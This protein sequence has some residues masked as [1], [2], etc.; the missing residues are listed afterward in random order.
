MVSP[1]R[2][3]CLAALW[4]VPLTSGQAAAQVDAQDPPPPP[5]LLVA[6]AGDSVRLL[7]TVAPPQSGGFHV[8]RTGPDGAVERLTT[9][10]VRRIADP[11]QA[12]AVLGA[13]LPLLMRALEAEDEIDLLRRLD[14]DPFAA[15]VFGLL[16]PHAARVLGRHYADHAVTA[17]AAYEYRVVFTD[18]RGA[19]T[20]ESHTARAVVRQV[21]PQTPEGVAAEQQGT[22][23]LLSWRYAP[24][25]GDPDDIVIGFHVYREEPA[26]A[27]PVRLTGTPLLRDERAVAEFLDTAV[28]TGVE[29]G[30]SV[31]AVDL[32]GSES[33]MSTTA[34]AMVVDRTPP[35]VP[36]GLRAEPGDGRVQLEWLS[37]TAPDLA[38]YHV[39]RGTGLDRPFLR[40]T[41]APLPAAAP[42]FTD[43]TVIGGTQYF[44]RIVA[45]DA[46]GNESRPGNALSAL[47]LDRTPPDPPVGVLVEV[48]DR[49][50][51]IRWSVSPSADVKGYYVY[52]G[53]GEDRLVRLVEQPVTGTEF[54]D[55]G[56][57]GAGLEPGEPYNVRVTAVDHSYNESDPVT[58]S[59]VLPDDE[60]PSPPTA[61]TARSHQGRWIE[62]SWSASAALDVA[63]YVLSRQTAGGVGEAVDSVSASAPRVLRDSTVERGLTYLYSL[64]AVDSAG[65]RSAA[66]TATVSFTG[67]APPPAPR[68]AAARAT[69]EGV[70]I[71]WERVVSGELAGYHVYRSRLP[72]G[73][74]ERVTRVPVDGLTFTD[75][76]GS[77]EWFY[78]VRAIDRSG[79]ESASSPA[80]RPVR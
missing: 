43:T 26:R 60:P 24:Y 56:Y 46:A 53:G 61:F 2:I 57:A 8:Y 69:A 76:A 75:A 29:Y 17:G 80:V 32:G 66:A 79:R 63:R 68:F 72:T 7:L 33:G 20:A 36:T 50:L 12:V 13:D 9:E 44:Y 21:Q 45:V 22:A 65:N 30:Y 39:E 54:T 41:S 23:V 4:L 55:A 51:V 58:A 52:R 71:W 62:L 47:P 42:F 14:R 25:L 6:P 67:G 16:L 38:G 5:P 10:P 27:V 73:A 49:Q 1:R 35:A 31:R 18:A 3:A 64:T 19:E 59:A 34:T 40:L 48:A 74:P 77:A 70:E 78:S 11:R 37:A 15:H 28:V